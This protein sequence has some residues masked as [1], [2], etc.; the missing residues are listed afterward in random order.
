MKNILLVGFG[1]F[2]GSVLR[3]AIGAQIVHFVPD[4]KFPWATLLVNVVGCFAV[5]VVA[6]SLERLD[7]YNSEL[8]LLLI[9]GLLGGFTTFSA[10][11]LETLSLLRQDLWFLAALN[12]FLSIGLGLLAVYLGLRFV[13]TSQL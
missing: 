7:F 10:F 5:G 13:A 1:G 3:Y 6:F 2:V 12:I 4:A 9:T 11:G 8:R